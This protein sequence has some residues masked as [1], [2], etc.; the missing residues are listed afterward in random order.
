MN[1]IIQFAAIATFA[2]LAACGG[3]GDDALAENVEQAYDNQADQL[4]AIAENSTNAAQADA[5]EGQA[6]ALRSEGDNKADAIDA[7]DVNAA[8]TNVT[9]EM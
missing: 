9:N 5:L 2:A 4:D 1:R 3:K 7:A 6:D 8:A